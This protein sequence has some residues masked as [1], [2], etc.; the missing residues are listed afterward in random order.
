MKS[1]IYEGQ[2][3]HTRTLPVRHEFQYRIFMMY[4]DLDELGSL[5]NERW[6]WS[7]SRPALARFRRER[8]LGEGC[9]K[10]AV[11]DRVAA[12]TGRHLS[13]PVRLL[14]N[15]SYYGYGFNPVSFF[16]CFAAD[17]ETVEAIVVEVNNTPW[18]EQH[19]YVEL[20]DDKCAANDRW[21]FDVAKKMH[22][23]PFM[24]M[25]VQYT[26]SLSAPA[27]ELAVF[28]ANDVDGERT[29]RAL[30]SLQQKDISAAS[31]ASVLLRYPFQTARTIIAI[32]W[33]AFRLW[34]KKVPLYAHPD[35]QDMM[36]KES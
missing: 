15:F 22:V 18:G 11:Y 9:L 21:R 10:Q 34:L 14:T 5:F 31:L 17:G 20:V 19:S 32:H 12:E 2:V 6:F 24:P 1:C 33:Q 3:S 8:H 29:F 35:K 7:T 23:S 26:W 28:M 27:D 25:G 4:V 16:Y 13:G 36:V 30:L